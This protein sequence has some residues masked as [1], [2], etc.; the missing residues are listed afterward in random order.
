M[1]KLKEIIAN[2]RTIKY[3]ARLLLAVIIGVALLGSLPTAVQ[4]QPDP[5]ELELGGE[6]AIGWSISNIMP[7]D[8][9]TWAVTL[10][11]TGSEDG[12]VTMWISD[13]DS[14]EGLNPESETGDKLPSG[15][16][17]LD[18]YLQF[19]LSST[20]SGRVSTEL[21]LP[22][23][24]DTFPQSASASDIIISPL[25]AGEEVTLYWDWELPLETGNDVQGDS[26]SFTINYLLEEFP[27][28]SPPPGGGGVVPVVRRCYLDIDM[29]GEITTLRI[30]CCSN[31]VLKDYVARSEERRVGKEC[32]L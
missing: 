23:M 15:P 21:S 18:D 8:S 19:S 6:G 30:T 14:G 3:A 26:L 2:G 10:S 29:L 12:F 25:D 4:A 22:G 13:I 32:R 1:N 11:N 31:E 27:P 5:V 24:I 17:E 16:G 28:P 9:G 7:G 20:P